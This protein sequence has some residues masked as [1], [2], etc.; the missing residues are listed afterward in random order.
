MLPRKSR[1]NK[2]KDWQKVHKKGASFY[3]KEA[4]L[5]Y[6]KKIKGDTRIGF[7]VGVKVSKKANQRNLIKRRL[8]AIFK[9]YKEDLKT[10]VDIIIITR[11]GIVRL[12]FK[13]LEQIVL[14][15]LRRGRLFK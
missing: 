1:V 14:G 10:G 15:L 9:K 12:S 6:I 4:V 7:I 2:E 8:R 13:E 11:P 5:K 3:S